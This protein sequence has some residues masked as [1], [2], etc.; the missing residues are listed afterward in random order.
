MPVFFEFPDLALDIPNVRIGHFPPFFDEP[1]GFIGRITF[2]NQNT[3]GHSHTAPPAT[4]AKN[5]HMIALFYNRQGSFYTSIQ[6]AY[7][8]R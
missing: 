5:V 4:F 7:R 2:A 8:N 1:H 6:Y 3:G